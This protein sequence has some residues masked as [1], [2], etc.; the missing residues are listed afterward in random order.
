MNNKTF[1]IKYEFDNGCTTIIESTFVRAT[2]TSAAIKCLDNAFKKTYGNAIIL[3]NILEIKES[4][5]QILK[6]HL[7]AM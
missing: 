2:S 4:D 6:Q 3:T 5:N 7:L 1:M